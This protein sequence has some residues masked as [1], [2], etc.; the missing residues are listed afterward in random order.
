MMSG[1]RQVDRMAAAGRRAE[2]QMAFYLN[3]AFAEDSVIR[4][5]SDVRVERNGEAAQMDHV[6]IHRYGVVIV[7]SKSVTTAVRVNTL[8]EWERRS[9]SQWRGMASPLLQAERQGELLRRLLHDHTEA[10]L[11]RMAFGAVQT[12]FRNMALDALVAISDS[13]SISRPSPDSFP[14]VMKADQVVP[15]IRGLLSRYRQQNSV[16]NF[17]LADINS[18]PRTFSEREVTAIAAFLQARNRQTA[19]IDP[20]QSSTKPSVRCRACGTGLRFIDW[21]RKAGYHF[22]CRSCDATEVITV[23]CPRCHGEA[24]I[25]KQGKDFSIKCRACSEKVPYFSNFMD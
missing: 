9:G 20:L 10:L 22:R 18:A 3:R 13:G 17:R 11:D 12:T 24:R 4:V 7:E 14:A 25:T 8:G 21:E 19:A 2:K 16:L 1:D 5:L 6:V 15:H 23:V